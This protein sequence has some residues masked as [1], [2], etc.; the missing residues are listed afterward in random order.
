[1]VQIDQPKKNDWASQAIKY[2]AEIG[3][4][5]QDIETLSTDKFKDICKLD[6]VGPIDNRP[7][8]D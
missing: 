3:Y 1:M 5:I 4:E 7:S 2:L 8:T 6:G